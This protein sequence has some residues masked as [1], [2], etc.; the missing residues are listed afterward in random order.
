MQA[1]YANLGPHRAGAPQ[2]WHVPPPQLALPQSWQVFP[3]FH[4]YPPPQFGGYATQ[5]PWPAMMPQHSWAMVA[6]PTT[7]PAGPLKIALF[8]KK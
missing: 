3:A 2:S 8:P 6:Y 4:G 7:P 1:R 5:A